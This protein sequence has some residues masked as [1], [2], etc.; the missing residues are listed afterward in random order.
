LA[1]IE[2]MQ[3]D[4]HLDMLLLQEALPREAGSARAESYIAMVEAY[5]AAGAR[6]PIAFVT[7]V[8]HGQ[9]DYSRALR[10]RAPHV[11]FLQEAN[12]ALRAI[13]GVARAREC[14]HLAG[15]ADAMKRQPT[16]EQAQPIERAIARMAARAGTQSSALT[17]VES[18]DLLRRYGIMSPEEALVTSSAAA[19]SAADRIG[20]PVV[21]KAVSS[22][23]THKSDLGAVALNL[24]SRAEVAA[25][26]EAMSN[27]LIVSERLRQHA[28]AGMLVCR[29]IRGGLE[30][31]LGLHRDPEM[32]LVV[33]AGSGGVLIE[34]IKD[35][36][37]CVP[38]VSP[39]KARHLIG[40]TRAGELMSGYRGSGPL[41]SE[42]VVA[43]LVGLGNLAVDLED[44]VES[45]DINPFVALPQGEGGLALDALVVLRR[46]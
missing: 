42:A 33:M 15:T 24:S 41:D 4:P 46:R 34:V 20:Y 12:K 26:Y 2:A 27:R 22:E 19:L 16:P 31:V 9:T 37:F 13:A 11:S 5:A 43:A 38:P 29:Q 36:A 14:E 3:A 6:K 1:S 8:S 30:L 18:K 25:E 32:G 44:V 45:I 39:D 35:V 21:L 7:P 10:A 40:R 28:L 17:E 23:L